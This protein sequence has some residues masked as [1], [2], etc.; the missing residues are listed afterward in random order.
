MIFFDGQGTFRYPFPHQQTRHET[1]LPTQRTQAQA[2]PRFSR[3]NAYPG[4]SRGDQCPTRQTPGAPERLTI[5]IDAPRAAAGFSRRLRLLDGKQFT[6]IFE[7]R[8]RVHSAHFSAHVAP[9]EMS[10]ARVGLAVSRRV[11][12][13]AVERNRIKRIIRESFRRHQ[14][15]LGA[16][17]YIV[18]AKLGAA[19]QA[20]PTLRAEIDH[21]WAKAR[22]Q[23]EKTIVA[24]R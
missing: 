4:G 8:R 19:G 5:S 9:N 24:N 17:D 10:H 7:R 21:L 16:V 6:A 18:I 22:R 12:K 23:G 1:Y 11:S 3:A 15:Q 20:N 14:D 2:N 13:K